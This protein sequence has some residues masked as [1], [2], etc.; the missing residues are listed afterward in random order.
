[1]SGSARADRM[2]MRGAG[3]V[4]RSVNENGTRVMAARSMS[5]KNRGDAVSTGR[6]GLGQLGH[7]VFQPKPEKEKGEASKFDWTICQMIWL[8]NRMMPK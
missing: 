7:K 1:M 2:G 5:T 3:W 6:D 4:A 8:A